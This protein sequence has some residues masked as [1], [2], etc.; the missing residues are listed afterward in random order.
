VIG[1]ELKCSELVV[2]VLTSWLGNG[3]IH[4]AEERGEFKIPPRLIVEHTWI[5]DSPQIEECGR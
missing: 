3:R 1:I 2:Q 4:L 5:A